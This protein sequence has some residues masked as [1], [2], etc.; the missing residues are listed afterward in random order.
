[1]DTEQREPPGISSGLVWALALG[2]G[3]AV[4]NLYYSQPILGTIAKDLGVS[5]SSLGNVS[6]LTQFGFAA[7]LLLLVP[8]GDT[9]ERRGLIL[10]IF[11]VLTVILVAVALSPNLL[12]LA[13]ASLFMGAATAVLQMLVPLAAGLAAPAERG[14]VV[15]RV[16]SGLL[17]GLLTARTVSGFVTAQFG[18]RAMYAIA[19][20]LTLLLIGVYA[21]ILPRSAPTQ[22]L[23]YGQL[24]RSFGQMLATERALQESCLFGAAAFA[25][26]S[27][28]WTTLAF[29]LGQPPFNYGSESIGLFGLAGVAGA[30][31]A[32]IAGKVADRKGPMQMIGLGLLLALLSYGLFLGFA[33]VL[34]G[35]LAGVLLLDF[36]VQGSHISNQT[37]IYQLPEDKHNRLNSVY[38]VAFFLGGSAGSSLGTYGWTQGGWAGVC[39]V[40]GAFA[41][42]GLTI[43]GWIVTRRRKAGR[44]FTTESQR[45]E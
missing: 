2:C 21:W 35:L 28:F 3:I 32:P 23:P 30:L 11:M 22:K 26:F 17:V 39:L 41:L 5:E 34:I 38:M 18:W 44:S 24:L 4:A 25:A 15:G 12:S 10:I 43:F 6:A 33:D 9:H 13:I 42:V 1:M 20:G 14:W 40:G 8:L 31:A 27:A 37:R 19:A 45:S 7:G 36:G 16:M 29:H